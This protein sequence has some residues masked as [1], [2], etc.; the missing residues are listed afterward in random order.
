MRFAFI[1][2]IGLGIPQWKLSVVLSLMIHLLIGLSVFLIP[3]KEKDRKTPFMARLITPDEMKEEFPKYPASPLPQ[4][5]IPVPQKQQGTVK[6]SIP[7]RSTPAAPMRRLP[8]I[9]PHSTSGGVES[10]KGHDQGADAKGSSVPDT[11]GAPSIVPDSKRGAEKAT[12]PITLREKLFDREIIGD[13]AKREDETKKDKAITFD[14]K[15]FR[16]HTYMA[17]L[18]DKIEGIWIYPADAAMR[19]IHGDLKIRFTI[20]KDGMLGDVELVRTSGH[21]SLDDAAIRAL[22]D[23][24]PFWPLPDEWNKDAIIIDGYFIY[25][26]YGIYIR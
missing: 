17:R 4:K 7:Q 18:K 5:I 8:D 15:E 11:G 10:G 3:V 6:P 12:P 9:P 14:T 25:S 13:L 24:E 26:I 2:N 16:H 19:G 20:K 21:R 1:E 22:K 23:A